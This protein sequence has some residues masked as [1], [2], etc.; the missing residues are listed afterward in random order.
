MD[1]KQLLQVL[2]DKCIDAD[3]DN[4]ADAEPV[5]IEAIIG[6]FEDFQDSYQDYQAEIPEDILKKMHGFLK[7]ADHDMEYITNYGKHSRD[8]IRVYMAAAN[9][10]LARFAGELLENHRNQATKL[11]QDM[12]E[13]W[14]IDCIGYKLDMLE[15]QGE[16]AAM[17][18]M[19][20]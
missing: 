19:D 11:V 10:Q 5:W 14:M 8:L 1:T 13:T 15:G 12:A 16:D 4:L 18:R 3:L 9:N 6:S 17:A 2:E 7:S 20:R